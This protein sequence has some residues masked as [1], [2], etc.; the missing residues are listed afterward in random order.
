MGPW[1]QGKVKTTLAASGCPPVQPAYRQD[2]T[3]QRVFIQFIT[4][5]TV[6]ERPAV[7]APIANRA[8]RAEPDVRPDGGPATGMLRGRVAP[9]RRRGR[10][11]RVEESLN[12]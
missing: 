9:A 12:E 4:A 5:S 7:V 1:G 8:K 10:S 11:G 2:R 6:I 3:T